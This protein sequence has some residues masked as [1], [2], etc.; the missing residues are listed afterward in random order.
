MNIPPQAIEEE[1]YVL[2]SILINS[3]ALP[4]IYE[5]LSIEKFYK[6]AHQEIYKAML[7]LFEDNVEIDQL[8]VCDKLEKMGKL[9]E[10]GG[11]FY[12]TTLTENVVSP[13]HIKQHAKTISEKYMLRQM[14]ELSAEMSESAFESHEDATQILETAQRKILALGNGHHNGVV[15]WSD[16]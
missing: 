5:I 16:Y 10:I 2:G 11:A 1:V 15:K 7:K 6:T 3:K 4:E 8:T 13:T 9:K 12:I 14:I